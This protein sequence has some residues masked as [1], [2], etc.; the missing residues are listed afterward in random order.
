MGGSTR[1]TTPFLIKALAITTEH[2]GAEH[3]TDR[4]R[5]RLVAK[6]PFL[7]AVVPFAM[8]TVSEPWHLFEFLYGALFGFLAGWGIHLHSYL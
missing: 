8:A 3:T 5:K 7:L 2:M 4:R 1:T 6:L